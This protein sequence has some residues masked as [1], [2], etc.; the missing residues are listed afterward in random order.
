MDEDLAGLAAAAQP[1]AA[2][3]GQF[4]GPLST[5]QISAARRAGRERLAPTLGQVPGLVRVLVLWH[6]LDR[7][8]TVMH[9]AESR[10]ALDG[11]HQGRHHD[12]AAAR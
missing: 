2:F 3:V 4:D 8:M 12:T 9:L 10:E 1:T 11:R 5:A 6:P 7:K